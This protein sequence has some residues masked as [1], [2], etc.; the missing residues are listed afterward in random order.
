MR[1]SRIASFLFFFCVLF[2]SQSFFSLHF[3]SINISLECLSRYG[4]TETSSWYSSNHCESETSLYPK[5]ICQKSHLPVLILHQLYTC[6]L[7]RT[8]E[9]NEMLFGLKSKVPAKKEDEFSRKMLSNELT[10]PPAHNLT[11]NQVYILDSK[12][13]MN[14]KR[15]VC[16]L[17]KLTTM[18]NS[19]VNEI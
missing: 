15:T 10:L 8:N 17:Q 13:N 6:N 14:K 1:L 18:C 7:I 16:E 9:T 2:G 5:M 4:Q 19:D 3:V 12:V 11:F